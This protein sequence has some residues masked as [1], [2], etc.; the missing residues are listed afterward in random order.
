MDAGFWML[1]AAQD[2]GKDEFLCPLEDGKPFTYQI[3]KRAFK[4]VCEDAALM[5]FTPHFLRHGRAC[6]DLAEGKTVWQ[7]KTK[8]A[9]ASVTTTEKYLRSS[10]LVRRAEKKG[11]KHKRFVTLCNK[12]G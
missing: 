6:W 10:E 3:A 4:T 8:L 9:H 7:V 5:R 2:R 11:T 12:S 1:A